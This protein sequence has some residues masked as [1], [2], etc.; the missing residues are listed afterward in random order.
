MGV[1]YGRVQ[2]GDIVAV[3]GVGPVGLAAVATAGL[4]GASKVI[5]VGR[6]QPRID[7]ALAM[8]ATMGVSSNDP[9]WVD[10][11]MAETDGLGVDVVIEAVG[12]P[13]TLDQAFRIVRPGGHVANAGVHG[14]SFSL[15]IQDLWIQ[16]ITFTTGL[17]DTVT[18]PILIDLIKA[19]RLHP[20]IMGT[21]HFPMDDM[22]DA[23]EIFSHASAHNCLKTVITR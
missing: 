16:N 13:E 5:A 6:T 4:Y 2:P 10:T 9:N 17:V 18:I 22:L 8:G 19:G 11:V 12:V 7:K 20:E 15:P 1:R 3:V 21:H 23:Y 14:K